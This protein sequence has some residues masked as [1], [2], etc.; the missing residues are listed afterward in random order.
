M[1]KFLPAPRMLSIPEPVV[2]L[3][4]F[5]S[6]PDGMHR[7]GGTGMFPA[8]FSPALTADPELLHPLQHPFLVQNFPCTAHSHTQ[9]FFLAT[10]GSFMAL[11]RCTSG[12][13]YPSP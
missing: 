11:T 9:G 2:L 1:G 6:P 7:A 4:L 5:P 12:S 8:L 3:R 10:Y 13:A